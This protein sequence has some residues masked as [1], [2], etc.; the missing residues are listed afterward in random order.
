MSVDSI[1]EWA[2]RVWRASY[3]ALETDDIDVADW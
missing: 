1:S 3:V 2:Y